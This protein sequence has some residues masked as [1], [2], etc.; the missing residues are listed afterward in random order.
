MNA[1]TRWRRRAA[2]AVAA[3]WFGLPALAQDCPPPVDAAPAAVA[4]RGPLWSLERDGRRSWLYGTLH[5]GRPGWATPGPRTTAALAASDVVALELDPEDPAVQ[6]VLLAEALRPVAP[7]APELA[8]RLARAVRGACL[9]PAALAALHPAMQAI[10]VTLAEARRAG[11]DTAWGQEAA[12]ARAARGSGRP[13]VAL[14]TAELQVAVLLPR[15]PE[16]I[17]AAVDRTLAPLESGQATAALQRL[18]GAWEHADLAT[19]ADYESWCGCVADAGD[20]EALRELNDER[21]P[22]LADGIAALHAQGRSVFAAV[23]ALHMTGPQ[24]LPRLLEARG[25]VVRPV[26]PAP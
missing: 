14:E 13:L 4:D 23:G 24:A 11:L 9:D 2:A 12:L 1:L 5:L 7:L 10:V 21:N 16:A 19:I 15:E 8:T 22:A 20:H 6:R 3:L 18:A 17:A 26:S 25:F